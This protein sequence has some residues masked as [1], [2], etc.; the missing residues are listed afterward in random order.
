MDGYS[1]KAE[2][3]FECFCKETKKKPTYIFLL[4]G[5]IGKSLKCEMLMT[6]D[7]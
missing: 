3:G 6:I 4:F 5:F 1:G 7:K 2:T